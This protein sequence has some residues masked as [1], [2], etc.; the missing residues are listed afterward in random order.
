MADLELPIAL[1]DLY[2]IMKDKKLSIPKVKTFLE[3]KFEKGMLTT[4]INK[5]YFEKE[6]DAVFFTKDGVETAFHYLRTMTIL[7]V[8]C[9]ETLG[10]SQKETE[11]YT[12][13]IFYS[14]D[15]YILEKYCTLVGHAHKDIP[16]G[17][18]CERAKNETSE[19]VI[20][21]SKLPINTPA[22]IMYIK[23]HFKPT[24]LKL[25][26]LGLYPGKSIRIHQL[27]PTYI[28]LVEQEEIAIEPDVAHSI[29]VKK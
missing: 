3:K 28:L 24:I 25:F 18:C 7:K 17:A 27:Y 16:A 23:T 12:N 4:I 2:K 11:E 1:I 21:L 8:F 29:F 9:M 22:T 15:P 6:G 19:K 26:E 20:P 10:L 13:K 5:G 14:I